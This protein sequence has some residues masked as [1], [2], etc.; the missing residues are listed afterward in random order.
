[1]T[2]RAALFVASCLLAACSPPAAP[3]GDAASTE[4][5]AARAGDTI[6]SGIQPGQYR[7]TVTI[8]SMEMPGLPADAAA[9]MQGRPNVSEDCV[10]TSDIAELTRQSLVDADE[11]QTCTEN[12]I[13]SANGRIQGSATCR[14][15]DGGA[16]TMQVE[17]TY[18]ANHIEMNMHMSGS[19]PGGQMNQTASIVTDRIGECAAGAN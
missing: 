16:Y 15:Q 2:F 3:S 11:G 13:T 4:V 7:T 18:G 19:T 6:I 8:T 12:N 14:N 5:S 17:G 10:T 1:M 9:K